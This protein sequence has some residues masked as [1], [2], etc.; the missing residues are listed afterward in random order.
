MIFG[1][2]LLGKRVN[3]RLKYMHII[4]SNIGHNSNSVVVMDA[5]YETD[6]HILSYIRVFSHLILF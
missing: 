3:N 4:S 6:I 1:N 5:N 2:W